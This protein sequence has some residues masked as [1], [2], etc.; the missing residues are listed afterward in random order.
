MLNPSALDIIKNRKRFRILL[1]AY[2]GKISKTEA[3]TI[4]GI[5]R[6][7]IYKKLSNLSEFINNKDTKLEQLL[8]FLNKNYDKKKYYLNE[9]LL[10]SFLNP[11]IGPKKIS[12]KFK[13]QGKEISPKTIW[14]VLKE[15]KLSKKSQREDFCL[16]YKVSK[17]PLVDFNY[18]RLSPQIR[19]SLIEACL[20]GQKVNDV[21]GE[22]RISRK[23]LAKWKRRYVEA[24]E[25]GNNLL[26]ALI[27]RNPRGVKHYNGVD[28]ATENTILKL[29]VKKFH[30]IKFTCCKFLHGIRCIARRWSCQIDHLS[31]ER[32]NF[33]PL[34]DPRHSG[35]ENRS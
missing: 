24:Q 5:S 14:R 26:S 4:L 9:I 35:P 31:P 2:Q 13:N 16:R 29:V 8:N 25:G 33:S 23:T 19:K 28:K 3:S 7:T 20:S 17:E 27:D 6:K 10:I 12:E 15:F 22:Y 32:Q 11:K 34:Q 21:C 1:R 18:A 30:S